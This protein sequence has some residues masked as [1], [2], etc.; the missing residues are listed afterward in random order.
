M[1]LDGKCAFDIASEMHLGVPTVRTHI[2]SILQKLGVNNQLQAVAMAH[3]E[4]F[5]E[6]QRREAFQR[7]V[8]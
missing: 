8:G 7:A 2:R 1:M 3:R 5:D 6:A 4:M